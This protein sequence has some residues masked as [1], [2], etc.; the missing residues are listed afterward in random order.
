MK[1]QIMAVLNVTPDSFFDGGEY[2]SSVSAQRRLDEL[3]EQEVDILD[4]GAESTRP[5]TAFHRENGDLIE[6][7]AE[8]EWK[9]LA[10]ILDYVYQKYPSV[11]VSL[12]S[13]RF[14]VIEKALSYPLHMANYVC[15]ELDLRIPSLL[16]KH[17]QIKL[18]ICHMHGTPKEMQSGNYIEEDILEYQMAWFQSVIARCEQEG[19]IREQLIVDP[20]IGFGKK[21]PDQNIAILKGVDRLRQLGLPLGV[22]LS[23]KSFMGKILELGAKDLLCPTLVLNTLLMDRGVEYIR[24][25]DA[26][27]HMQAKRLL[28]AIS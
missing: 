14:E 2:F 21:N 17:P 1:T 12:D 25:H 10:P 15:S 9:R 4:I 3:V 16:A 6:L 28:E 18:M 22:G 27:E 23:R 8:A 13:R 26:K 19:M 11:K 7:G 20:G 24:V 5:N